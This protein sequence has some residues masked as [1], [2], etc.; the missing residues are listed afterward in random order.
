[1]VEEARVD[2]MDDLDRAVADAPAAAPVTA[3]PLPGDDIVVVP[4]APAEPRRRGAWRWWLGVGAM[5]VI[6][7]GLGFFVSRGDPS[8]R[9]VVSVNSPPLTDAK[10]KAN[11]PSSPSSVPS[12]PT[13]QSVAATTVAPAP[14]EPVGSVVTIAPKLALPAGKPPTPTTVRSLPAL[15]TLPPSVLTWTGP[16]SITVKKGAPLKVT[17]AAHNPTAGNVALAHPLACAPKLDHSEICTEVL[18]IIGPGATVSA[19]Y[20]IAT[21]IGPGLFGLNVGGVHNIPVTV[22]A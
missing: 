3:E 9:P 6:A 18:Q 10:T 15:P 7:I 8:A 21:D 12:A 11:N 16:T 13:K 1:V 5:V 17:V 14:R 20:T 2:G 22:T 19:S 4:D